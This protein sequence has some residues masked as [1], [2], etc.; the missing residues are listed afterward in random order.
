[1]NNPATDVFVFFGKEG[2]VKCSS[3]L[4]SYTTFLEAM[5]KVKP[6]SYLFTMI[7]LRHNQIEG[8]FPALW[9]PLVAL[10]PAQGQPVVIMPGNPKHLMRWFAQKFARTKQVFE[11]ILPNQTELEVITAEMANLTA[12]VRPEFRASLESTFDSL[13]ADCARPVTDL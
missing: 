8:G 13:K 4:R 9:A 2:S 1:V 10:Y 12:R 5:K 11:Y 7:D 6:P 3:W